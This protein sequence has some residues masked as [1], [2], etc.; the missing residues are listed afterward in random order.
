MQYVAK[1]SL[2][3]TDFK[4][5]SKDVLLRMRI[6][7]TYEGTCTWMSL[8]MDGFLTIIMCLQIK[9]TLFSQI[10]YGLPVHSSL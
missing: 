5:L 3:A 4:W 9:I 6:K 1:K 2:R 7:K 10:K 8:G